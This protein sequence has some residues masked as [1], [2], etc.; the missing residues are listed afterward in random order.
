MRYPYEEIADYIINRV[1]AVI[2]PWGA[3]TQ[4]AFATAA[5]SARLGIPVIFGS[6]GERYGFIFDIPDEFKV[7]IGAHLE[8]TNWKMSCIPDPTLL[9]R[10]VRKHHV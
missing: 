1:G 8:Q 7:E 4:K 2:I 9:K 6:S 10:M 3:F 5:G